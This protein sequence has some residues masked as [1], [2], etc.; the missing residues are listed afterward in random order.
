M[1]T[2]Q[3]SDFMNV[4]VTAFVPC[5]MTV[6]CDACSKYCVQVLHSACDSQVAIAEECTETVLHVHPVR[7]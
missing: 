6:S 7:L 3:Q 2:S 1:I 4:F 5:I